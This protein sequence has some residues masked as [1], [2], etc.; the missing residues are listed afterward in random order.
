MVIASKKRQP[1]CIRVMSTV[2][3]PLGIN[4][5]SH[6]TVKGDLEHLKGLYPFSK[7]AAFGSDRMW[8]VATTNRASF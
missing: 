6:D 8:R 4:P 3:S 1:L 5:S 7:P 2:P